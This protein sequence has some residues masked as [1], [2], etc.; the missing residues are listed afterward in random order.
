MIVRDLITQLLDF[1]ME[2]PVLLMTRGE[3]LTLLA[4]VA[5]KDGGRPVLESVHIATGRAP[6]WGR[7]CKNRRD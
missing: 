7:T 5:N 6:D 3:C 4:R 1:D 2:A